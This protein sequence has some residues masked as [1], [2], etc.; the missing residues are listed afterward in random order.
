MIGS[1]L[2]NNRKLLK[3]LKN[4]SHA[5]RL[6]LMSYVSFFSHCDVICGL[7]QYTRTEKCN[8]FVI[9]INSMRDLVR[10]AFRL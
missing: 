8:L 7:L 2:K 4:N 6:R 3:I 10:L 5:T 9:Y 1:I